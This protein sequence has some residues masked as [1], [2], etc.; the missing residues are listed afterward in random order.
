MAIVGAWPLPSPSLARDPGLPAQQGRAGARRLVAYAAARAIYG[1]RKPARV[2][3]MPP[4]LT[5]G[6]LARWN[7][8]Q[9]SMMRWYR[10][11][12][13]TPTSRSNSLAPIAL[14]RARPR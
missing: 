13:D 4:Q 2:D 1:S 3:L 6:D 7:E 10:D 11:L 5:T 9:V 12:L 8:R 14:R